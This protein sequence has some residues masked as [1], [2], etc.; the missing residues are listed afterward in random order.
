MERNIIYMYGGVEKSVYLSYLQDIMADNIRIITS[1]TYHSPLAFSHDSYYDMALFMEHYRDE[2][3]DLVVLYD[4]KGIWELDTR[5]V[6]E[7]FDNLKCSSKC[8]LMVVTQEQ[9]YS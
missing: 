6:E 7:V 2:N 9:I 5:M 8:G 3:V 1:A 4:V